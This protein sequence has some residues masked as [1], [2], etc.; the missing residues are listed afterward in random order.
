MVKKSI[1]PLLVRGILQSV[2]KGCFFKPAP[3]PPLKGEVA[4]RRRDGGVLFILSSIFFILYSFQT[5]FEFEAALRN[6]G[7]EPKGKGELISPSLSVSP[8]T[9]LPDSHPL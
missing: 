2:K 7:G 6:V 1:P 3:S 5:H 4:R 9:P 8:H